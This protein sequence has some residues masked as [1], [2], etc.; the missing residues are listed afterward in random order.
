MILSNGGLHVAPNMFPLH[1]D[2]N[3]H[4]WS[5]FR[6]ILSFL[7]QLLA[8]CIFDHTQTPV[9]RHQV[10]TAS[11][12][13]SLG[14]AV[15]DLYSLPGVS[16]QGPLSPS[17]LLIGLA[18]GMMTSLLSLFAP[19]IRTPKEVLGSKVGIRTPKEVLGSKVGG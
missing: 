12:F 16:K 3:E 1:F 17:P 9:E 10:N 6:E 18:A 13:S 15:P 5:H 2:I 7:K 4:Y 8:L 14:D 19:G 11:A